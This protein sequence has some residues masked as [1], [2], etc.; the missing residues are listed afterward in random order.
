MTISQ[1]RR[2]LV[3]GSTNS[4]PYCGA[5]RRW[6][7]PALMA[8]IGPKQTQGAKLSRRADRPGRGAHG[9]ARDP[10]ETEFRTTDEVSQRDAENVLGILGLKFPPETSGVVRR[11]RS[12]AARSYPA[13]GAAR[14]R[15]GARRKV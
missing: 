14:D 12:R 5:S 13:V 2:A 1:N 3:P 7:V 4:C 8:I 15:T 9:D 10:A 11:Q 6:P